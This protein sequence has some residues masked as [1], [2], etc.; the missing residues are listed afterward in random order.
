MGREHVSIR[1]SLIQERMSI[2][3][4]NRSLSLS[5][6]FSPFQHRKSI[7][8]KK[9]IQNYTC[10]YLP[11]ICR[12]RSVVCVARGLWMCRIH[13]SQTKIPKR[14]CP[15]PTIVTRTIEIQ[16]L[17]ANTSTQAHNFTFTS[18]VSSTTAATATTA[19]QTFFFR[20]LLFSRGF[21]FDIF[22]LILSRTE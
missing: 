8:E 3:R 20:R 4:A 2:R 14:M 7:S 5:R 11:L 17:M 18:K 21:R 15:S 9:K 12:S 1:M 10:T 16:Q 22:I 19:S 13:F 6:A